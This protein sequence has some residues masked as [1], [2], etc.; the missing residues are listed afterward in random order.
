[1]STNSWILGLVRDRGRGGNH[2]T[3]A[4]ITK[5]EWNSP[6]ETGQSKTRVSFEKFLFGFAGDGSCGCGCGCGFGGGRVELMGFFLTFGV[7]VCERE[8]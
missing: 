7:C 2:H 8:R 3:I 1:M 5:K 4:H 6:V